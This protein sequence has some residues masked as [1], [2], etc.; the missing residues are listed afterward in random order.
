MKQAQ[1]D[2][3][4]KLTTDL[5]LLTQAWSQFEHK[6]L[7]RWRIRFLVSL[8]IAAIA[9]Y[10]Y[11]QAVWIWWL[12]LGLSAV[13]LIIFVVARFIIQRKLKEA[14]KKLKLLQKL[15]QQNK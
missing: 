6:H 13:S 5:K 2:D 14:Q 3:T 7:V 1:I 8:I 10:F 11:P 9:Y 4:S 15:K 12:V